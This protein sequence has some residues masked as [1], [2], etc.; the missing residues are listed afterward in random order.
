MVADI[1]CPIF[2]LKVTVLACLMQKKKEKKK[3]LAPTRASTWTPW[4]AS[5]SPNTPQLQKK[6][7]AHIFSGLPPVIRPV[8]NV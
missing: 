2:T 5:I 8:S 4:W 7:C 3:C 6:L 1:F